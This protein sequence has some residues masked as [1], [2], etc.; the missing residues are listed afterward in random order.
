MKVA[1]YAR[2]S[3]AGDAQNPENQLIRLRE[4]AQTN[5]YEVYDQYIDHASGANARRPRFDDMLSDAKG[6]RFSLILV[7]KLDRIARSMINFHAFL[8]EI[9]SAGVKFH[10]IDQPDISTDTPTGK[11]LMSILGAIAEFERDLISERTKDGLA[12]AVA[13]GS[14]LGRK[15][16]KVDLERVTELRAQGWGVR[17]IALEVGVSHETL[18]KCLRNGVVEPRRKTESKKVAKDS[19]D[20]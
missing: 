7:V 20:C 2:V 15:P 14:K 12:R 18:R 3:K 16:L 10:C 8:G 17:C 19:S 5:G 4:Y 6:H 13:G 1:L 9:S 11:L